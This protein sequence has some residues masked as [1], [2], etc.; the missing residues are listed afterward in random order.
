MVN[1][2]RRRG[3]GVATDANDDRASGQ[4]RLLPTGIDEARRARVVVPLLSSAAYLGGGLR[5][6]EGSGRVSSSGDPGTENGWSGK[7]L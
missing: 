4:R 7:R 6:D 3:S 2:G 1:D 5:V